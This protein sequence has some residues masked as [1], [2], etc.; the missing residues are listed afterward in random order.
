MFFY[1]HTNTKCFGMVYIVSLV[2]TNT[3]WTS[4]YRYEVKRKRIRDED[5]KV[6]GYGDKKPVKLLSDDVSEMPRRGTHC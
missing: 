1:Y 3:L 5:G 2:D 4:C 6:V